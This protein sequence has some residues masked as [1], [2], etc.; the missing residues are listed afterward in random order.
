MVP[1][2]KTTDVLNKELFG[3]FIYLNASSTLEVGFFNVSKSISFI[4]FQVHSHNYNVTLYN[5]T[6]IRSS[7][8][9]GT[10]VGMYSSVKPTLDKFFVNNQN[11]VN[12]EVYISVHGYGITGM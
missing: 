11:I 4:I 8:I 9:Y 10:N 12:I 1:L 3:E 6:M 2:N 5:N 7:S